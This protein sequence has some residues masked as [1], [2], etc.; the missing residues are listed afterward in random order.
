MLKEKTYNNILK[1]KDKIIL[2]I[3]NEKY[4]IVRK[5]KYTLEYYLQNFVYVLSDVVHWSSLSLI[6]KDDNSFHWF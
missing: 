3:A 4:P 2:K 6:N 1:M 5:R